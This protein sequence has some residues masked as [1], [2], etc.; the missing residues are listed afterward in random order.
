LDN[1]TRGNPAPFERTDGRVARTGTRR[2]SRRQG[3]EGRARRTLRIVAR[4]DRRSSRATAR[5]RV[6]RSGG[7]QRTAREP[8]LRSDSSPRRRHLTVRRCGADHTPVPCVDAPSRQSPLVPRRA[9]GATPCSVGS[10]MQRIRKPRGARK[11]RNRKEPPA[12]EDQVN[13]IPVRRTAMVPPQG[14]PR[15]ETQAAARKGDG[16][17]RPSANL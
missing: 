7:Q 15:G 4:T 10:L 16:R 14:E 11:T 6:E 9:P 17:T 2:E 1:P 12:P 5:Q 8:R 13:H 3:Q